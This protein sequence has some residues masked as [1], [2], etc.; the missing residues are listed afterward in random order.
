VVGRW[1]TLRRELA[2]AAG[3]AFSA[4]AGWDNRPY[5]QRRYALERYLSSDS[6]ELFLLAISHCLLKAGSGLQLKVEG[7]PIGPA[8]SKR[9]FMKYLILMVFGAG[10]LAGSAYY[11]QHS[12]S[13]G[14]AH[15][16]ALSEAAQ[17]G[18]VGV[19]PSSERGSSARLN[20]ASPPPGDTKIQADTAAVK[21]ELHSVM[22]SSK[23]HQVVE[24]LLSSQVPYEQKRSRWKELRESGGLDQAITEL[25]GRVTGNNACADC[26]A[27]LGHAYLQKCGTISDVREQGILAMQADKLFD[28]AL[29]LDPANWEARFTKAVAL[30][31]WPA[32]MNKGEEVIQHFTT[33]IQQQET[34]AAQPQF[35]ETYAWLGDQYQ[36]AGR[37][38]DARAVWERGAALF[39]NDP[40]LR[41]KTANSP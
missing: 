33:L 23:V 41:N 16:R 10:V 39:P 34:Q 28:I 32:T 2:S 9:Q 11:L 31:Y 17:P 8:A 13:S 18:A 40:K 12:R 22:D 5:L 4:P 15:E 21:A 3:K 35:A 24:E 1:V 6:G 36:K 7:Q 25:E 27:V 14:I 30:S 26:A 37:P 20:A 29:S 38:E 19:E